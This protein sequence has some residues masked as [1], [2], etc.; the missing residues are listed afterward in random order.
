MESLDSQHQILGLSEL[1]G[2]LTKTFDSF[3]APLTVGR[4]NPTPLGLNSLPDIVPS[5]AAKNG[6]QSFDGTV[7]LQNLSADES[8]TLA[9]TSTTAHLGLD[10]LTGITADGLSASSRLYGVPSLP[11]GKNPGGDLLQRAVISTEATLQSF[12]AQSDWQATLSDVFGQNYDQKQAQTFATA[13]AQSDFSALPTLE[14][15][16]NPILNG[17]RG[18]YDSAHR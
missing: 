4:P 8:T 17:A 11:L 16:P 7:F 13:F 6:K 2:D 14:V 18:G 3:A 15:L 9:N 5:L 10:P 12:F 1:S